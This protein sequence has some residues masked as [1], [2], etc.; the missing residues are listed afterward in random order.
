MAQLLML[1]NV[2]M[3]VSR[4]QKC[5]SLAGQEFEFHISSE[6]SGVSRPEGCSLLIVRNVAPT[7]R[8]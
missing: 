5:F 7:K 3:V 4:L 2:E 6:T 1:L 8:Q